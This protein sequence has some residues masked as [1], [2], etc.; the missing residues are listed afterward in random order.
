MGGRE[1][2]V[3]LGVVVVEGSEVGEFSEVPR[4]GEPKIVFRL[5]R[6]VHRVLIFVW[7]R[8]TVIP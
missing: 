8:C 3:R 2:V 4:I 5:V 6:V 1:I 7:P